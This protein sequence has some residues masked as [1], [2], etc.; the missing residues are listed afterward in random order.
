MKVSLLGWFLAEAECPVL[1]FA[2][3][4]I[5]GRD[6]ADS[7]ADVETIDVRRPR[8][9]VWTLVIDGFVTCRKPS[10]KSSSKRKMRK[11][12][13]MP[14]RQRVPLGHLV[15]VLSSCAAKHIRN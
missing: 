7:A 6:L 10:G 5:Q 1:D 11:I 13:K 12:W 14:W 4:E 3:V 9:Y 2:D 8:S 15:S